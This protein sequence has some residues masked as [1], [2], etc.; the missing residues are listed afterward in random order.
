[1]IWS[2]LKRIATSPYLAL[3]LRIYVGYFFVYA[4]VSKIPYPAQ[5]AEAT[6]AYRLVP[7]L[8]VNI[9]SLILPWVEFVAGLFMIIGLRTRAA[10]VLIGLML[11]MFI[12]MVLINM[13]W[14]APITCGCYD[15]VGE[16]IGWHKIIENTVLLLFTIQVYFF[17][18][19]FIFRRGGALPGRKGGV[20]AQAAA[21]R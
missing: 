1:M 7:Y 16:P 15:T 3:A 9:G 21:S 19:L 11:L 4:S 2:F 20:T 14:G 10:A 12:G 17:D 13:Y 18:R 5:F 8:F 6:A